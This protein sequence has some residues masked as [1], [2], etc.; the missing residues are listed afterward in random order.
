MTALR[1]SVY[2][3]D[4]LES[5]TA[6]VRVNINVI[7]IVVVVVDKIEIDC[8]IAGDKSLS[9]N[10]CLF[11]GGKQTRPGIGRYYLIKYPGEPRQRPNGYQQNARQSVPAETPAH[12]PSPEF[13]I[14]PLDCDAARKREGHNE[15]QAK[16]RRLVSDQSIRGNKSEGPKRGK[17]RKQLQGFQHRNCRADYAKNKQWRLL[18]QQPPK[19]CNLWM[20]MGLFAGLR[21]KLRSLQR[22]VNTLGIIF[23]ER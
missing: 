19:I 1:D 23:E 13:F 3:V 20:F 6:R 2:F 7:A 12:S 8:L 14:E 4:K 15:T 5:L 18:Q 10:L 21:P 16:P 17:K 9:M 11:E 22:V